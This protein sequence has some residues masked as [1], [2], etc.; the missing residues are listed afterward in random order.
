MSDQPEGGRFAAA[1]CMGVWKSREDMIRPYI[2]M[3][4]YIYVCI[5][6]QYI[7]YIYIM[8]ILDIILYICIYIEDTY[9]YPVT[10]Y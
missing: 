10:F 5:H 4:I 6:K 1:V 8:Y 3:N 2:Y 7:I 9:M